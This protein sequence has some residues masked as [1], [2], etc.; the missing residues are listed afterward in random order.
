MFDYV[1]GVL[2]CPAYREIYAE[3]LKTDFPRIPW[4]RSADEFWAVADQGEQLRRLHLMEPAAIGAAI[5]P[6]TG[7]GKPVIDKPR[8]DANKVWIN[9]TQYFDNVP[10]LAWTFYIG[11]Y[12]P[13]Q[14]WLKDR[15][16]KELIFSD[17]KHYQSILKI[18]S[19]TDRIMRTIQLQ[20]N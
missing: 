12:Q 15:K 1:Y 16:G 14:K 17:I 10:E 11:G 18:L 7:E 4:S 2:Y 13:A 5:Y 9:T 20:I 6:F 19:E 8:Y 3:F